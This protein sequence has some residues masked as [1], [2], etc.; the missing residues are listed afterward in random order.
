MPT[1]LRLFCTKQMSGPV[2]DVKILVRLHG[3]LGA[4]GGATRVG[5][6]GDLL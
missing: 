5:A 3:P 1:F 2:I 4:G 6:V